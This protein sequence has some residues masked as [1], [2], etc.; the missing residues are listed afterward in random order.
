LMNTIPNKKIFASMG[1]NGDI[2]DSIIM[3]GKFD[4]VRRVVRDPEKLIKSKF[5]FNIF[6]KRKIEVQYTIVVNIN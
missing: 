1:F 5:L 4:I 3:D 6:L 2:A